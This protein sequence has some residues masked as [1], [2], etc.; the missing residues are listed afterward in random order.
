MSGHRDEQGVP[1]AEE[2]RSRWFGWIWAV[3]IA[4][5]FI[6]GYLVLRQFNQQGPSV[7]VT[8]EGAGGVQ[9]D[10]TKVQYEGLDVGKVE[11]SQ[12]AE[13]HAPRRRIA[14]VEQRHG[15][16]PGC[17]HA[18]LDRRNEAEH[19]RS[20]VAQDHNCRAVYRG[21]ATPRNDAGSLPRIGRATR[22]Q[23]SGCG[24]AL[25][26]NSG[27]SRHREPGYHDLLPGPG[28]RLGGADAA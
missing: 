14:A 22:R 25:H 26:L 5:L 23:G 27:N 21:G 10:N 12:I 3:P 18:L 4:A 7:V 11:V 17:G 28:R 19:Q 2:K 6:V 9:A 13:G 15:G 1:Q 24:H 8:F 16:A 20:V